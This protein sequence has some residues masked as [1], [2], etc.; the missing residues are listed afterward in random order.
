M[1]WLWSRGTEEKTREMYYEEVSLVRVKSFLGGCHH[2]HPS[3]VAGS[4]I[5]P[6]LRLRQGIIHHPLVAHRI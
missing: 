6:V 5:T 4:V 2:C 3:A 1:G